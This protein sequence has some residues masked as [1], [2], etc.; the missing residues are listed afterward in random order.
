MPATQTLSWLRHPLQAT[1]RRLLRTGYFRSAME[2]LLPEIVGNIR[3]ASP[4]LGVQ[5]H[6]AADYQLYQS[7]VWVY[8]AASIWGSL[9]AQ[10]EMEVVDAAGTAVGSEKVVDHLLQ[11]PNPDFPASEIW[12]RWGIEL[13][14]CGHEGFEVAYKG[15]TPFEL[16]P[17][18][19]KHIE[20]IPDARQRIYCRAAGYHIKKVGVADYYL[21]LD[22]LIHWKFYH[23]LDPYYGLSPVQALQ[24]SAANDVLASAWHYYIFKNGAVP[25]LA[26]MA[27]AMTAK[28]RRAYEEALQEQYGMSTAGWGVRRP[29]VLE[30]GMTDLKEFGYKAQD[31]EWKSLREFNREDIA[32]AYGIPDEIMGFG[33]NT[34]ENFD[35]AQQVFWTDTALPLLRFRDN[36]LTHWCRQRGILAKG[37]FIRTKTREIVPLRRVL[38][39]LYNQGVKL[40]S[41]GVP[42][43]DINQHFSFGLPHFAGDDNSYPF[44]TNMSIDKSGKVIDDA[45]SGAGVK[46]LER[47][48]KIYLRML[49]EFRREEK[50]LGA[51]NGHATARQ[52]GRDGGAV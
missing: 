50:D 48:R 3:I 25:G 23:P 39:P 16:W 31:M 14:L 17:L 36:R 29:L 18:P 40:F 35:M 37:H 34:Y 6:L 41:M 10:V 21:T 8:R 44:G 49:D 20:V 13:A 22:D 9:L 27:P 42:F 1:A 19:P 32:G 2:Q 45:A 24:Y 7:C 51:R 5:N 4:T 43:A 15:A 38:D 47:E 28:E 52:S 26:I 11:E 12:Q 30:K 33:K 46:E